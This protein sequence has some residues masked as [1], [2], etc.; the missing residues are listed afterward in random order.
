[1]FF[2]VTFTFKGEHQSP[3]LIKSQLQYN[4]STWHVIEFSRDQGEGKLMIDDGSLSAKLPHK[5]LT[6]TLKPPFNFGGVN[7]S[8][9]DAV[10]AYLVS[11]TNT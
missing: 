5:T 11:F 10:M 2:Q 3:L 9:Q 4:D 7:A 8:D 6:L 1:M